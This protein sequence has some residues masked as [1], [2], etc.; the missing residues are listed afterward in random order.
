M[1]IFADMQL[2]I[3]HACSMENTGNVQRKIN[4]LFIV[5]HMGNSLKIQ[6]KTQYE[7]LALKVTNQLG[8]KK[9]VSFIVLEN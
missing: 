6:R 3:P 7:V 5:P 8:F 4:V 2:T 1:I 9:Y